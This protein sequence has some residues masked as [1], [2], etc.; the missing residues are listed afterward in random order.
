MVPV[1]VAAQLV[2]AKASEVNLVV[3]AAEPQQQGA[4]EHAVPEQFISTFKNGRLVTVAASH[5]GG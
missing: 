3:V 2:T 4:A 1:P 5:G